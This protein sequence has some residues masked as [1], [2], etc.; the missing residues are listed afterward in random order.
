[1]DLTTPACNHADCVVTLV[2]RAC[3]GRRSDR[4]VT[5]EGRGWRCS[6]CADPD[7]GKPPLEFVD[8]QLMQVNEAA[9]AEAWKA[10]Y[11]ED[12]PPSGRPGRKTDHPRTE[13]VAVLLTPEELD[14]VDARRGAR[15]RSDFLRAVIGESLSRR[16]A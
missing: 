10:K 16:P 11:G 6:R 2:P 15:S 7:T 12:L 5:Y 8:A 4:T 14:R 9:L 3:M 13:R 1:M